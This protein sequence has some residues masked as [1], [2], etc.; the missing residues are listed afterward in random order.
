M[1]EF[2]AQVAGHG[3]GAQAAFKEPLKLPDGKL[4]A[5]LVNFRP[6]AG[7]GLLVE[8]VYPV[9]GARVRK[10]M[11]VAKTGSRNAMRRVWKVRRDQRTAK[12]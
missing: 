11:V 7:A 8:P 1:V 9:D 6:I 2:Q 10:R 12:V 4:A 3:T 5:K